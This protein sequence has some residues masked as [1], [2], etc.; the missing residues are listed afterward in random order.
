MKCPVC[1]T[2]DLVVIRMKVRGETVVL[3]TCSA[4]D[5]RSWEGLDG[6]LGLDSVL[7]LAAAS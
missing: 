1:R 7:G 4:C 6:E 3:R 5:L 2:H